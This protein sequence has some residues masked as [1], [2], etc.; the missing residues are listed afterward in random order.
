VARS[1]GQ[2]PA[3]ATATAA[4]PPSPPSPQYN[5][6]EPNK[7]TSPLVAGLLGSMAPQE[8]ALRPPSH[9]Q[10]DVPLATVGGDYVTSPNGEK[11]HM[12][13]PLPDLF[14]RVTL[15]PGGVRINTLIR[16][17]TGHP[18]PAAARPTRRP[19]SLAPLRP[20]PGPGLHMVILND[21]R[22]YGYSGN[23]AGGP[24]HEP[25]ASGTIGLLP[26]PV[27]ARARL[28]AWAVAGTTGA[29]RVAHRM[30]LDTP[31]LQQARRP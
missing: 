20:L 19:T 17:R 16:Q 15:A 28:R 13:V 12:T 26:G 14:K 8:A 21:L 10:D 23:P 18:R 30:A 5:A 9:P 4:R 29:T 27:D 6:A 24:T 31:G 11:S 22:G 7:P 1:C 3:A 25:T 2:H